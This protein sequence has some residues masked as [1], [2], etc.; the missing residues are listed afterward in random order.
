MARDPP[1]I[2][3]FVATQPHY[4]DHLAPVWRALNPSERGTF[5]IGAGLQGLAQWHGIEGSEDVGAGDVV[6][7][8][9]YRDAAGVGSRKVVLFEHGCGQTYEGRASAYVGGTGRDHIAMFLSPNDRALQ[10][11][12]AAH[13]HAEHAMVGTPKMDA[14]F[15]HPQHDV[16]SAVGVSF[17]WDAP[18]HSPE[19]R[20]AFKHFSTGVLQLAE[21]EFVVGHSHP[22]VASDFEAWYRRHGIF[23][24]HHFHAV[25]NSCGIYACDNSSTIFEFAALDRPVVL[26]NAPAYRREVEH[27]LRFWECADVGV[28]VDDPDLLCAAV[29][30]AREDPAE[31]RDR[32]L[33]VTDQLFP[34]RDGTS[35][36]RAA[37]AIRGIR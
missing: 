2:V 30:R 4:L 25:I 34:I 11:N 16:T 3:D 26:M 18:D 22:S 15:T 32:R 28:Q 29:E 7:A 9:A 27:G 31:V 33:E 1:L 35:A 23:W 21:R 37:E 14:Y 36:A 20:S 10:L 19:N 6:V 24:A 13:R 5:T 12:Q 8:A 17:H